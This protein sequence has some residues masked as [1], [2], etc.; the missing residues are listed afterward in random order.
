M[1]FDCK[2]DGITDRQTNGQ[3][4]GR[5]DYKMPPAD[6][7]G[8]GHKNMV[9]ENKYLIPVKFCQILL[10]LVGLYIK[11][12]TCLSQSQAREA[13]FDVDQPQNRWLCRGR[14]VL[15]SYKIL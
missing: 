5:S 15:D 2:R 8:R 1:H 9:G 4:D 3:T 11:S 10:Y 13:M 14:W 12:Q 6:L 7:S